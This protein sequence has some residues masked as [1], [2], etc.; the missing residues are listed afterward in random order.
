MPENLSEIAKDINLIQ[1]LMKSFIREA[2]EEKSK[3]FIQRLVKQQILDAAALA[4][5]GTSQA[6]LALSEN[7]EVQFKDEEV[8]VDIPTATV[9]MIV[10][11]IASVRI[12]QITM[13]LQTIATISIPEIVMVKRQ[14]GWHHHVKVLKKWVKV[15][16]VKTKVPN[17]V[18]KWKTPAYTHVPETRERIEEIKTHVPVTTFREESIKTSL[19]SVTV[20]MVRETFA[21]PVPSGLNVDVQGFA[22]SMIP[23]SNVLKELIRQLRESKEFIEEF[24]E[25]AENLLEDV[26][27]KITVPV[28]EKINELED[29]IKDIQTELEAGQAKLNNNL[30]PANEVEK[31]LEQRNKDINAILVTIE[32]YTKVLLD[33]EEAR[34]DALQMIENIQFPTL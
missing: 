2:I 18:K 29:M 31:F 26:I 6:L 11:E 8:I 23:A 20:E 4:S 10:Q 16:F 30:V 5:G 15:G 24:T 13:E 32:Q 21:V 19:P 28:L 25:K 17:G 34:L 22:L 1:S 7:F 12:P 27:G 3:Q 33:V 14:V 9:K